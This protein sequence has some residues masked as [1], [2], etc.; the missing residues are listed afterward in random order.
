MAENIEVEKKTEVTGTVG[1][2]FG[3]LDN[4]SPRWAK[5]VFRI[6]LYLCSFATFVLTVMPAKRV[7]PETA[8]EII[9]YL[10]IVIVGVHGFS[11]MVGI[12][13]DKDAEDAKNAFNKN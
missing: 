10:A 2:G 4:P 12:N 1:F 6:V 13:I 3:Q 9:G 8:L 5:W 7:S 11:K